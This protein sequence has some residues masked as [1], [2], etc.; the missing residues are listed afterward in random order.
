MP[1]ARAGSHGLTADMLR[2]EL[3]S[4]RQEA[5]SQELSLLGDRVEKLL[6][7]ALDCQ[8]DRIRD[9]YADKSMVIPGDTSS[10][11]TATYSFQRERPRPMP[12]I[13]SLAKT[14]DEPT[15]SMNPMSS[16]SFAT[17]SW[18]CPPTLSH[19]PTKSWVFKRHLF[20][21]D[22][23]VAQDLQSFAAAM[24]EADNRPPDTYSGL[25]AGAEMD[26]THLG[27]GSGP[28]TAI[29]SLPLKSPREMDENLHHA[30]SGHIQYFA[31][32]SSSGEFARHSC[33]YAFIQSIEFYY[34]TTFLILLNAISIGV[35]TDYDARHLELANQS[36]FIFH[37]INRVSVAIFSVEILLRVW[38]N[39]KGFFSREGWQ[40]RAFDCF[41]VFLML[42][43]ELGQ[44][45]ATSS[46]AFTRFCRVAWILRLVR[47]V[48]VIRVGRLIPMVGS[49]RMLIVS[50]GG[51]L[52]H[53]AWTLVL[54][55]LMI[56]MMGV[57]L[58]ALV[59][60]HRLHNLEKQAEQESLD[61][62]YG[63]LDRS[64]LTLFMT[65]S[66]GIHWGEVQEPLSEFISPWCTLVFVLYMSFTLFA[67]LNVVT[68]IFVDSA[69]CN[70]EADKKEMLTRRVRDVFRAHD[71]DLSGAVCPEEFAIFMQ[72][73]QMIEY[74]KELELDVNE[75]RLL[76][77][78]LDEDESGEVDINEL[79]T[80]C[81]RLHGPAKSLELA[82]FH[83]EHRTFCKQWRRS[84]NEMEEG[85]A[86]LLDK[87]SS[88]PP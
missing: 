84:M 12:T 24:S 73:P 51:A 53:L 70:A 66:E 14:E 80:G 30:E 39:G 54:L 6:K 40:W 13:A 11:S 57:S 85:I 3:K 82:A 52:R 7:E 58:T 27:S 59:T 38:A 31:S 44:W 45:A 33:A 1:T 4:F 46:V 75:S 10:L 9:S 88:R 23:G 68:G 60:D 2:E 32:V 67:I 61:T 25:S 47:V 35:E 49:L 8:F 65:M 55:L 63:T 41:V 20:A 37:I 79:F 34:L 17:R 28:D 36:P 19:D 77:D 5:L 64:M 50:I 78:L 72:H 48:R 21:D 22:I 15:K 29:P 86:T 81:M 69:I 56:Y 18:V 87:I 42:C 62:Y 74:M 83:R 26:R 71:Q 43:E 16:K 76:F